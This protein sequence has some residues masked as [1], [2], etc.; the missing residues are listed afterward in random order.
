MTIST[1]I[2][3]ICIFSSEKRSTR[4]EKNCII[5]QNSCQISISLDAIEY[6]FHN[7]NDVQYLKWWR[8]QYVIWL[9]RF[10]S[11]RM[12]VKKEDF[13]HTEIFFELFEKELISFC[14]IT[15]YHWRRLH[16]LPKP[17]N[18]EAGPRVRNALR[19]RQNQAPI[20]NCHA[21]IFYIANLTK[22]VKNNISIKNNKANP[23]IMIEFTLLESP[24]KK[25]VQLSLWK[26]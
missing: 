3:R 11:Y 23:V 25:K 1:D 21:G 22:K 4:H 13:V 9:P 20:P 10:S 12:C 24:I 6:F 7:S 2:N 5:S 8:V 17:T 14:F 19:Q 15:G 16:S 18:F 26:R